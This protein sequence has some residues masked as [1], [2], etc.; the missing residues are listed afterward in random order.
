VRTNDISERS[1]RWEP[2]RHHLGVSGGAAARRT[3]T[4]PRRSDDNSF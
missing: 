3:A 4:I 2:E 1:A